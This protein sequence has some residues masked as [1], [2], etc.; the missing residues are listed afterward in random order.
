MKLSTNSPSVLSAQHSQGYSR[1]NQEPSCYPISCIN[2]DFEWQVFLGPI[3]NLRVRVQNGA[4]GSEFRSIGQ[5]IR[6]IGE[7][8]G[9]VR[10]Q[11][12]RVAIDDGTDRVGGIRSRDDSG[13]VGRR[14]DRHA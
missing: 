9:G 11:D 5:K 8:D 4:V 13:S 10:E 3:P 7:K 2:P 1:Q 6:P 14:V 12:G